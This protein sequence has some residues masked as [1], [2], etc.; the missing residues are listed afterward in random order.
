LE[1]GNMGGL[2]VFMKKTI[3]KLEAANAYDSPLYKEVEKDLTGQFT[4]RT[5]PTPEC[6]QFAETHVNMEVGGNSICVEYY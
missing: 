2:P 3:K 1:S 4:Y 5:F 6:V